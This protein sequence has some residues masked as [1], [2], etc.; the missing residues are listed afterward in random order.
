MIPKTML[1]QTLKPI[2]KWTSKSSI[3]EAIFVGFWYDFASISV[4]IF[5]DFEIIFCWLSY[6]SQ[7]AERSEA[8]VVCG[9]GGVGLCF[10]PAMPMLPSWY[11]HVLL[12]S[13]CAHAMLA[14]LCVVHAF[15]LRGALR[16]N[17]ERAERSEASEAEQGGYTYHK[18]S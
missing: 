13:C 6:L 4:Y 7:S 2:P 8:V 11:A 18:R 3:F 1:F 5:N 14:F 16:R 9:G 17:A 15:R 12:A 10:A